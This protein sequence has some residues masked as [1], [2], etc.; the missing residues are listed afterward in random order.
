MAPQ[1][2]RRLGVYESRVDRNPLLYVP[3]ILQ[4]TEMAV[5]GMSTTMVGLMLT[6][7]M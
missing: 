7:F 5:K 6:Y 1:L 2:K 3:F 4:L